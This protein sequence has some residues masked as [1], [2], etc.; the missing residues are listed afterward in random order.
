MV[1]IG[2]VLK[3]NME[4]AKSIRKQNRYSQEQIKKKPANWVVKEYRGVMKDNKSR[5]LEISR[6][7]KKLKLLARKK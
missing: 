7:N 3:A 6:H 2:S 1:T 5:L 4:E